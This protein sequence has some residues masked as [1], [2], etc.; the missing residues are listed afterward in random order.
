VDPSLDVQH[1][2]V[3]GHAFGRWLEVDPDL[4]ALPALESACLLEQ[5]GATEEAIELLGDAIDGSPDLPS[6]LEARGAL[7]FAAGFPRAAAGDFQRAVELHPGARSWYALGRAHGALGLSRQAL[8]ALQRASR[9]GLDTPPLH[10][11]LARALRD[12]GRRGAAA[13][14]YALALGGTT[15]PAV[16]LR[17][18]ALQLASEAR[19]HAHAVQA[20]CEALSGTAPSLRTNPGLLRAILRECVGE[21]TESVVGILRA[22]EVDPQELEDLCRLALTAVQ[23]DD[24]ETSPRALQ[25]IDDPQR[26][27]AV[28]ELLARLGRDG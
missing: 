16:D 12:L 10:L 2:L 15:E 11:A 9:C 26:R 19:E 18:E 24:P 13:G 1:S 25:S 3:V 23:L 7:Y 4:R 28:A 5:T 8:E 14:E 22:M 17:V 6:L 20:L 21:R 27:A